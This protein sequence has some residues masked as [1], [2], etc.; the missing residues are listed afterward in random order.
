MAI[1]LYCDDGQIKTIP[2]AETILYT[3]QQQ[4]TAKTHKFSKTTISVAVL[5][6]S[7]TTIRLGI[8]TF[9][10]LSFCYS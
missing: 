2:K 8:E 1:A 9:S 3:D 4:S 7:H 10:F 6:A 5:F